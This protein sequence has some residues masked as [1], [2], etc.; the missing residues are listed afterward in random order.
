MKTNKYLIYFAVLLLFSA[1]A[2]TPVHLPAQ[3]LFDEIRIEAFQD[4]KV[5]MYI[6]DPEKEEIV[7]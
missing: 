6:I 5:P 2:L 7:D 1:G 3:T 4:I